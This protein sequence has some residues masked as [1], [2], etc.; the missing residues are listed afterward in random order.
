M[1]DDDTTD[2]G[3]VS[4]DGERYP[5]GSGESRER[6]VT[7][8]AGEPQAGPP[9]DVLNAVDAVDAD[10]DTDALPGTVDRDDAA[11]A[12]AAARDYIRD[13]GGATKQDLVKNVMPGHPLVYDVDAALAKIDA[14]D[15]YRGAWWRNVVSPGLKKLD[16]VQTPPQGAST[17]RY[18]GEASVDT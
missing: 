15:R 1:R 9:A 13:H 10:D 18:A 5:T 6:G 7:A 2:A 14:G 12:V 17:W 11:A 8:S 4:D 16:D 3:G